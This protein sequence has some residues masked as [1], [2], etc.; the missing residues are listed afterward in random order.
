MKKDMKKLFLLF[1]FPIFIFSSHPPQDEDFN[2]PFAAGL[3]TTTQVKTFP[4][5]FVILYSQTK[6]SYD[7][8]WKKSRITTIEN[9]HP[10]FSIFTG[11]FNW[12][13]L[14]IGS[15]ILQTKSQDI[16][17]I[18]WTDTALNANFKIS[19]GGKY[20]P[21]AVFTISQVVPSG[22]F[23]DLNKSK[24]SLDASGG[25]SYQTILGLNLSKI[26]NFKTRAFK[27][28]YNINYS[29]PKKV[30]V[31]GYNAYGGIDIDLQVTRG[32]VKPGNVFSNIFSIDISLTKK[33]DFS[34]D[35]IFA[36]S[37][38]I[39]FEGRFGILTPG[40]RGMI[41]GNSPICPFVSSNIV[42]LQPLKPS[43]GEFET[44]TAPSSSIISLTPSI[45]YAFSDKF[46]A[47]VTYWTSITGRNTSNFKSLALSLSY[48]F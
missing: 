11:V 26:L 42:P 16:K 8:K 18:N 6:F 19:K 44:T 30:E 33:L 14:S 47:L 41:P 28:L 46:T 12:L 39:K 21:K 43:L 32:I 24:L 36:F 48:V 7:D 37:S 2:G 38:K 15:G 29:F 31:F 5:N 10:Y 22:K 40:F 4:L 9:V 20:I 45:G 27:L 23:S 13:S 17:A 35:A 3:A 1:I 34:M 25:G